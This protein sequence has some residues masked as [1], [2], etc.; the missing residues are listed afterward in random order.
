MTCQVQDSSR[1]LSAAICAPYLLLD[2]FSC[3]L[4][5]LQC[6]PFVGLILYGFVFSFRIEHLSSVVDHSKP[7]SIPELHVS[8]HIITCQLMFSFLESNGTRA[9]FK[10][11]RNNHTTRQH[12][13]RK[14]EQWNREREETKWS[15][16]CRS[17]RFGCLFVCCFFSL[18][19]WSTSKDEERL[20]HRNSLKA[21]KPS[22]ERSPGRP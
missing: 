22:T 5:S 10:M 2:L 20:H 11:K 19:I 17:T 14:F 12:K 9:N 8:V 16:Y 7:F 15:L 18:F 6:S 21:M 1:G 3:Y 4:Q 13:G